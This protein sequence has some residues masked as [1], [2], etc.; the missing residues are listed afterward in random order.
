M[1]PILQERKAKAPQLE[2]LKLPCRSSI[3]DLLFYALFWPFL[4]GQSSAKFFDED[5]S[6]AAIL[7]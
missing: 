2:Q 4:H 1:A 3:R 6:G 7:D 5:L